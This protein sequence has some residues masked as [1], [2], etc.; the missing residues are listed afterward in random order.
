TVIRAKAERLTGPN[1]VGRIELPSAPARRGQPVA[2][3]SNAAGADHKRKRKRKDNA[4]GQAGQ[5][6][7]RPA[8]ASGGY[9][10]NRPD[11]R[12]AKPGHG[13]ARP[14]F[15]NKGRTS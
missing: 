9:Q 6:S 10:G 13:T 2:S 12:N 5:A 8:P 7:N 14:D 4:P 11:F 1:V 15:R 3:S